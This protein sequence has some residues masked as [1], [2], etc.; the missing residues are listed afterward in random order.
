MAKEEVHWAD[1]V[2]KR[3]IKIMGNRKS[4]TCAAGITPSGTIHIGNFREVM[5]VY[6]VSRA[7][8]EMGKTVRFIYSWDDYDR[9]RKIPQNI[10]NK[11]ILNGYMGKPIRETPD[12]LD[13]HNS[14]AEHF[15]KEFEG[16]LKDV[17]IFPEFLFQYE[18]YVEC[19]YADEMKKIMKNRKPIK[20]IFDEYRK[21][22]LDEN[23]FPMRVYC[24]KCKTDYTKV[25]EYDG[26]YT[27]K[28]V[29]ECGNSESTNF[30]KNGNVKLPWRVDWPMRWN[31][32]GVNFEPAG[33]EH[34]TVGGSRMTGEKIFKILY[35]KEP[36]VYQMYDFII[37]KGKGGK[38]SSSVGDVITL[39]DCLEI[40]EPEILR[41]IFVRTRPNAE[42]AIS[43][44]LDVFQIYEQYDKL[45]RFYFGIEKE[46]NE[47]KM[48]KMKREYELSQLGEPAKKIPIQLSFRHLTN[49]VQTYGDVNKILKKIGVKSND[50]EKA[51][52]R[53]TC[54]K[55][56]IEKY[57]PEEM[58][59]SLNLKMDPKNIDITK[60]EAEAIKEIGEILKGK[61]ISE[62]ELSK[63]I[64][65]ICQKKDLQPKKFFEASYKVLI[66]KIKGPKL[67]NFLLTAKEEVI[68]IIDRL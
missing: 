50:K 10:P 31:Y 6:L 38:M 37:L 42:F 46:S 5:T 9:L 28:Y 36:P 14:Y 57:A 55:N 48:Q 20:E 47:K 66:D 41:W 18:N 60:K 30:K 1:R 33:K 35:K 3:I 68:K 63:K 4:Y 54:A 40:Y 58:R 61:P 11:E 32:E 19:K 12:T 23:W 2:A 21:E 29:C 64:Y 8:R 26:E 43:L 67:S 56:W 17:G 24:Q 53:V 39:K 51:L 44:D 59:F 34:S 25:T 27:I 52:K 62:E 16:S 45:E 22:P 13:C 15:E 65:D 49:M 7:L